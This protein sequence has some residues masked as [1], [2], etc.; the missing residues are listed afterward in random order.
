MKP[1]TGNDLPKGKSLLWAWAILTITGFLPGILGVVKDTPLAPNAVHNYWVFAWGCSFALLFLGGYLAK[2]PT[3]QMRDVMIKSGEELPPHLEY[4][5]SAFET[6]V[7]LSAVWALLP[8]I[9][10]AFG[11]ENATPVRCY[12]TWALLSAFFAWVCK[13]WKKERIASILRFWRRH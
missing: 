2:A 11:V 4:P 13:P 7:I 5:W 12:I 6:W 3:L 8:F 9:P 10:W 1:Q